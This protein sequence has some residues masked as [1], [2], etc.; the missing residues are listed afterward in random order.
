MVDGGMGDVVKMSDELIEI[1]FN[2]SPL[3]TLSV[4]IKANLTDL[5]Q[6]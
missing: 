2:K 6:A 3:F 4:H 1:P 5:I